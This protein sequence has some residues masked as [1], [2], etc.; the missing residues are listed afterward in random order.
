MFYAS[1]LSRV[2]A[3][4]SIKNMLPCDYIYIGVIIVLYYYTCKSA[5]TV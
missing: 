2:T 3:V 1:F 4:V 5:V